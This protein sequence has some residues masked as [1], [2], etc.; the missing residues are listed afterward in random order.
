MKARWTGLVGRVW[1][2]RERGA[3]RI[4]AKDQEA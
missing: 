2:V 1:A 4:M 3:S